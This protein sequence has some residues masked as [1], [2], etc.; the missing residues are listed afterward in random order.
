VRHAERLLHL[1]TDG[2]LMW[3]RGPEAQPRVTVIGATTD[4]GRLPETLVSRFGLRP[5][6]TAYSDHE[7]AMIAMRMAPPIFTTLAPF[8]SVADFEA[9]AR[10]ASNNPRLIRALL[11]SL[12]DL[13]LVDLQAVH[14]GSAY[15]LSEALM[16][17]GLTGDGLTYL[18]LGYLQA[19]HT[20]FAGQAGERS[21]A[22]RLQEPGGVASTERLLQDKGLIAKTRAGRVLTA[23]GIRGRGHGREAP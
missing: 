22:D 4:A 5:V 21:I 14:D 9:V 2:V 19:L 12:R 8:P 10:A 18:A 16:W 17:L 23:A 13:A 3:P 11:E 15:D 7:G 1:L 6:L 20:E